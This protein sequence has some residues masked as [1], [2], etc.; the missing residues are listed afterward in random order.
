MII[1][2]KAQAGELIQDTVALIIIIFLLI[3]FI[4]LST[5]F[6]GLPKKEL[7]TLTDE[8]AMHD[9]E[10]VSLQAWLQKNIEIETNG[11]Q[12]IS[13]SDLIRLSEINQTYKDRLNQELEAFSIYNYKF[14]IESPKEIVK[15]GYKIENIAGTTMLIPSINV[16]GSWFYIPSNKT[17]AAVLEIKK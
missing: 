13:I 16:P 14:E 17:I 5:T 3:L 6:W 7:Q 12:K 8:K 1:G 11:I 9:Q 10:H 2:K 15:T 4:I